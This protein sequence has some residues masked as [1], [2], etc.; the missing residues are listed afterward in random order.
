MINDIQ[1]SVVCACFTTEKAWNNL[2]EELKKNGMNFRELKLIDVGI[3][4]ETEQYEKSINSLKRFTKPILKR[5]LDYIP[6]KSIIFKQLGKHNLEAFDYDNF[7]QQA[8][9]KHPCS[10]AGFTPLFIDTKYKD[11]YSPEELANLEMLKTF[12]T[13][14]FK[15]TPLKK[16][17]IFQDED[18]KTY[19]DKGDE[20]NLC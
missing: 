18:M 14:T 6:F 15:P 1:P 7:V 2:K 4:L 11:H 19:E 10:F 3:P 9:F 16:Q 20:V 17:G 12:S 13:R 8:D 5:F